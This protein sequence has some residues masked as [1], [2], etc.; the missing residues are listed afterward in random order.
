MGDGGKGIR[1]ETGCKRE[2]ARCLLLWSSRSGL[3]FETHVD[4][5]LAALLLIRWSACWSRLEPVG[6]SASA[7]AHGSPQNGWRRVAPIDAMRWSGANRHGTAFRGISLSLPVLERLPTAPN[8]IFAAFS[9]VHPTGQRDRSLSCAPRAA[10][11]RILEPTSVHARAAGG[12]EE[13][14]VDESMRKGLAVT[15]SQTHGS[16]SQRD[17]IAGARWCTA[18]ALRGPQCLRLSQTRS[19]WLPGIT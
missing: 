1:A 2:L 5:Q 15:M 8:V 16:K 7:S 12:L 19:A 18:C 10:F 11:P 14:S 3:C 17:S 13:A 6:A 9:M 4:A